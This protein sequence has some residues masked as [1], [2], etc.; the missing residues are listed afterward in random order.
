MLQEIQKISRESGY[1]TRYLG[2]CKIQTE[3]IQETLEIKFRY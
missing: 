3:K 2:F 1:N